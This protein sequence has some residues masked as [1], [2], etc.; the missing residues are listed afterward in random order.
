MTLP[1]EVHRPPWVIVSA[2][3][4]HTGGQAKA[5]ASLADYLARTGPRVHLVGHDFDLSFTNCDNVT[6]HYA[7]RPFHADALGNAFLARAGRAVARRVTATDPAAR[8]VA[9]GGNCRWAD[10]NWVHYLHSAFEPDLRAAPRWF[11]LKERIVGAAYRRSERLAVGEARIVVT[12]SVRTRDDVLARVPGVAPARVIPVYYGSDPAWR[13]ADS[14]E[15]AAARASFGLPAVGPVVVFVGGFGYDNRKG[16]DT[17]FDAWGRL[18][19]SGGWDATLVMAGGGKAAA[20]AARTAAA[21][22]PADKIRLIGFTDRVFDL[23]AAADLLVSPVRYE[24]FGLNVQEAVCRC[25]PAL[26]SACA[27]VAEL[28]PPELSDMVLPDADD[29]ADLAARLRR[30]RV[31]MPGWRVR[32]RPLSDRMRARS[33]DDMAREI[34]AAAGD[35]R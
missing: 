8:V 17:L 28:Y 31:D 27:G 11:Q 16:F 19:A 26:V 23:L 15:R 3:F 29:A 18:T 10:V 5:V 25:V 9:N 22:G 1:D 4:H 12:N 32:F 6:I 2:G 24:P 35:I 14:D 20:A 30:W 34:I 13:P 21:V 7:A 33:W